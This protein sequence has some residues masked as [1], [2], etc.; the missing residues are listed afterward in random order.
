MCEDT[1]D[2]HFSTLSTPIHQLP[3]TLTPDMLHSIL[4]SFL[5]SSSA[6]LE[7]PGFFIPMAEYSYF[8]TLWLTPCPL[9]LHVLCPEF[10]QWLC[11]SLLLCFGDILGCVSPVQWSQLLLHLTL[12]STYLPAFILKA[13]STFISLI[14]QRTVQHFHVSYHI[15]WVALHQ[16]SCGWSVCFC[17]KSKV[18]YVSR[19]TYSPLVTILPLYIFRFSFVI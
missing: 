9:L 3:P 12:D 16:Q 8:P 4:F 6:V 11:T 13:L 2:C 15:T 10:L 18:G 7:G 5:H 1:T 17:Q 19:D 14:Q